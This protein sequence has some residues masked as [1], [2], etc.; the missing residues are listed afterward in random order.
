[1]V[2]SK[3]TNRNPYG[4][5]QLSCTRHPARASLQPRMVTNTNTN[6]LQENL[7]RLD[8]LNEVMKQMAELER[9]PV[10]EACRSYE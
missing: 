10:S 7:Q 6:I 3:R 8:D 4:L 5:K 2:D 9:I 1:M